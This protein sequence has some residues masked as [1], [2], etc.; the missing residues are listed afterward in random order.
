MEISNSPIN[1]YPLPSPEQRNG[2]KVAAE[3]RFEQEKAAT[4]SRDGNGNELG[5]FISRAEVVREAAGPDY[6]QL[7]QRARLARADGDSGQGSAYRNP[8]DPLTVQRALNAYQDLA[9]PIEYGD[10][11]LL[12]RV[13]D[14]A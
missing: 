10:I 9:G 11:E 13:D 12:P 6:T 1:P 8:G 2:G 5:E 14:Y 7:L 4:E 3:R